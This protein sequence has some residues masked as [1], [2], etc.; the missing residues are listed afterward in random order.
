MSILALLLFAAPA[1]AQTLT[2]RVIGIADGD[3]VTVLVDRQQVKV[4]LADIDA[5][6]GRQAFGSRSKQALSDL[7]FQKDARLETQGKDR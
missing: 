5:P 6:E 7:C 3:T 4:R 1:H 2:G